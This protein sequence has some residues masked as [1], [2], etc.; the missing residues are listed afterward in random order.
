MVLDHYQGIYSSSNIDGVGTCL[1]TIPRKITNEMNEYLCKEVTNDE[2]T[3]AMQ[4]LGKLK[5]PGGD[6]LNGIFYQNH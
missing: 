6:R 4:S 5:A 1:A 3:N 2:I